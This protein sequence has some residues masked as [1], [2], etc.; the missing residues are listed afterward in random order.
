M[1]EERKKKAVVKTAKPA[2]EQVFITNYYKQTSNL[3]LFTLC[4][5]GIWS[6]P[7][8]TALNLLPPTL[9]MDT[10]PNILPPA[11]PET[12]LCVLCQ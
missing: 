5:N 2:Q 7:V 10:A 12:T 8:K 6:V 3:P 1:T 9:P 11:L 4:R